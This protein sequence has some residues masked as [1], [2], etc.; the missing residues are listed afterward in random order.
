MLRII[1]MISLLLVSIIIVS[2]QTEK[3]TIGLYA[4][5]SG[6]WETTSINP[7]YYAKMK[8]LGANLLIIQPQAVTKGRYEEDGIEIISDTP[9]DPGNYIKYYSGGY[10]T[11]WKAKEGLENDRLRTGLKLDTNVGEKEGDYWVTKNINTKGVLMFG[12][13]YRQDKK[14]RIEALYNDTINYTIDLRYKLEE[15]EAPPI[16]PATVFTV[17][18]EY[19][20][21][22][23]IKTTI[24][25][26]QKEVTTEEADGEFKIVSL[27][28][29]YQ[30]LI[31]DYG[32]EA[33][34]LI[35]YGTNNFDDSNP[36]QGLN[37]V[38]DY[39][40]Q[41]K[42]YI[43]YIDV[44]DVNIGV[45]IKNNNPR[46]T[47]RLVS[48]IT[49]MQN[50][51]PNTFKYWYSLDE[52]QT[53]DNYYPY[54]FVNNILKEELQSK[55]IITCLYPGWNGKNNGDRT[56]PKFVNDVNPDQFLYY[57]YPM[58]ES[59]WASVDDINGSVEKLEDTRELL[60]DAYESYPN[61]WYTI[62][63]HGFLKNNAWD[64]RIR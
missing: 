42:L 12:P 23:G 64:K 20:F 16:I 27:E 45:D 61:F 19:I 30:E 39:E 17:T 22:K 33:Q 13:H 15:M 32:E 44:Y 49:N 51:L 24:L 31:N 53:I 1:K 35:E 34:K 46:I 62:Q 55:P 10:Y 8:E 37:I 7:E 47:S 58:W 57:Y 56:I 54:T 26:A 43:D 28:Y 29:N 52:P 11:R 5:N 38:V 6:D 41:T 2:G 59:E 9:L 25:L 40:G 14:Y 3:F 50:K 21:K 48:Y 63:A 36:E 4:G 18:A 60:Q